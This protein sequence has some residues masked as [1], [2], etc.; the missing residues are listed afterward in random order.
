LERLR[1]PGNADRVVFLAA[2]VFAGISVPS[3][4]AVLIFAIA[5]RH[6]PDRIKASLSGPGWGLTIL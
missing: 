5:A 2:G 4:T 3:F 6:V 1:I